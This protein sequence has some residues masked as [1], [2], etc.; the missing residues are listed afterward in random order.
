M[1]QN[2]EFPQPFFRENNNDNQKTKSKSVG[3]QP[4]KSG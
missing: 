4:M 3:Q 1:T 2:R